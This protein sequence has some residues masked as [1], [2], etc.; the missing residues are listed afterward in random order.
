MRL[1]RCEWLK[2]HEIFDRGETPGQMHV[3]RHE[4]AMR[5]WKFRANFADL[6]CLEDGHDKTGRRSA[7]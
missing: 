3:I 2:Y 6:S 7:L 1:S 5:G 4:D